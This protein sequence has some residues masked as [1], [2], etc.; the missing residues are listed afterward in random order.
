MGRRVRIFASD[1][2]VPEQV[3]EEAAMLPKWTLKICLSNPG[4]IKE[5]NTVYKSFITGWVQRV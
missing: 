2:R 3:K 4:R 5:V 1:L